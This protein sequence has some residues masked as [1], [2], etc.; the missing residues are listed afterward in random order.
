VE[1]NIPEDS[2]F[3]FYTVF[4]YMEANSGTLDEAT[5]TAHQQQLYGNG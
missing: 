1:K 4:L 2:G 5:A 3:R